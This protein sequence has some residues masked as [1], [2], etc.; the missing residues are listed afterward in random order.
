MRLRATTHGHK[1]QRSKLALLA[2]AGTNGLHL[3]QRLARLKNWTRGAGKEPPHPGAV[4]ND[5]SAFHHKPTLRGFN[6]GRRCE[7]AI[8]KRG[9]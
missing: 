6:S 3:T 5:C 7:E 9:S 4:T 2:S 1:D 8:G